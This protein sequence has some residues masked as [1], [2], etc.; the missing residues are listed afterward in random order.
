MAFDIRLVDPGLALFIQIGSGLGIDIPP[1][2]VVPVRFARAVSG[3]ADASA[4]DIDDRGFTDSVHGPA[5]G[6]M[7]G[8]EV[9]GT[10]EPGPEVRVKVIRDRIQRDV[11]LFPVFEDCPAAELVFPPPGKP[12][13]E[14]GDPFDSKRGPDIVAFRAISTDGDVHDCTLSI[15]HGSVR[16]PVMA[17][18]VV[19]VYPVKLV[20][21][22]IHRITVKGV[23]PTTTATD[24]D[25]I[26]EWVNRIYAQA[27]VR[28]KLVRDASRGSPLSLDDAFDNGGGDPGVLIAEFGRTPGF[29][30]LVPVSKLQYK[31]GLLNVYIVHDFNERSLAG[32]GVNRTSAAANRP[33]MNPSL[34]LQDLHDVPA[35]QR[36]QAIAHAA[37]HEI[38]HTL[39][40]GHFQDCA[41]GQLQFRCNSM[42]ARRSLMYTDLTLRQP[43]GSLPDFSG[44]SRVGYGHLAQGG[45]TFFQAGQLLSTKPF[46]NLPQG[47]EIDVLRKAI[48][49]RTFTL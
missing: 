41:S 1:H 14:D 40:L 30:E 27:G 11:K 43:G 36:L 22:Q 15:R 39:S 32:V 9:N 19:R 6:V 4:P 49:A 37:A 5:V 45:T 33:P 13:D 48:D 34:F 2:R 28:F 29:V 7:R 44:A 16:G 18:M 24:F 17:R 20:V 46:K 35:G 31:T 12:L 25:T 38:G 42:W 23:A 26:F 21:V 47:D 10:V 8:K 3:F